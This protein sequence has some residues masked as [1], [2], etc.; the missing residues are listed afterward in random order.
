MLKKLYDQDT[1][2]IRYLRESDDSSTSLVEAILI[3][4]DLQAGSYTEIL[5]DPKAEK[6]QIRYTTAIA[7]LFDDKHCDSILEAGVGEATTLANVVNAMEN[8]PGDILGFDISW[9]RVHYGKKYS[10]NKNVNTVLFVGSYFEIPIADDAVDIVYTSHSIEPNRGKEKEILS[11]LYRITRKYLILLEPSN[12]L[13]TEQTKKHIREQYYCKDLFRHAKELNFNVTEHRIF[14]HSTNPANQTALMIIEKDIH[15]ESCEDDFFACPCCK[16]SLV[17]HK[18]NY[19][20]G[21]CLLIF[22]VI[23]GI[24]CLMS[25][26]GILGSKYMQE[27]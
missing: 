21:D 24:P 25:S 7:E 3:S 27:L 17:L 1:N 2:I 12:E 19:F 4:Y 22:P 6:S 15:S 18:G 8:I 5:K 26:C 10:K 11:E 20:C 16:N 14:D 9:S 23:D 13:G